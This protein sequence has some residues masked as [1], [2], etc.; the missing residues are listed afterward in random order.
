M[1]FT[2]ALGAC[3]AGAKWEALAAAPVSKGSTLLYRSESIS[4]CFPGQVAVQASG[5]YD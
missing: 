1:A 4:D 2:T 5:L 3:T